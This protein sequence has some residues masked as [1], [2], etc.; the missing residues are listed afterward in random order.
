MTDT[1][2]SLFPEEWERY[3]QWH[4]SDRS[5]LIAAEA[6]LAKAEAA[7]E[8]RDSRRCV[9]CQNFV[10]HEG[11]K[12]WGTCLAGNSDNEDGD[13]YYQFGCVEFAARDRKETP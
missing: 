13:V 10:P 1:L 12:A 11:S 6:L 4:G 8:E 3:D 9:R 5:K 2:K 7:L